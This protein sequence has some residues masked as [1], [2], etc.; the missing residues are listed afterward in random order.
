MNNYRFGFNGQEADNEIKGTGNSLEFKYRIYDSLLGRFLSVDPLFKEYPWN[1]TY[2]FAENDVIRCIDLEGAE[3][4]AKNG[5][6]FYAYLCGG[7]TM[8]KVNPQVIAVGYSIDNIPIA[9]KDII[10]DKNAEGSIKVTGSSDYPSSDDDGRGGYR[11]VLENK[12]YD[13]FP[14]QGRVSPDYNSTKAGKAIGVFEGVYELFKTIEGVI[15]AESTINKVEFQW[16]LD[17]YKSNYQDAYAE[18]KWA[19]GYFIN[20][21]PENMKTDAALVDITNYALDGT[22]PE[23]SDQEYI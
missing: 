9:N 12:K 5:S 21:L 1:S 15:N 20:F 2:A 10:T 8:T 18:A 16:K 11:P 3:K 19:Q 13:Y 6:L 4:Y 23:S 14:H 7:V 17:N 22:L